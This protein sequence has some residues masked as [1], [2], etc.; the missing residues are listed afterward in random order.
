MPPKSEPVKAYTPRIDLPPMAALDRFI[1]LMFEKQGSALIL[2]NDKPVTLEV[3]GTRRPVTK[4]SV[5]A[6]KVFGLI[7]EIMPTG[8]HQ[9]FEQ[10]D[11]RLAFA[12]EA[13]G[14]KVEV[15][16]ALT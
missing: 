3:Q 10:E 11:G 1:S 6:A 9:Q 2:E 12:Y 16:T 4:E 15:G 14:H 7:K 13:D 5:P 8:M